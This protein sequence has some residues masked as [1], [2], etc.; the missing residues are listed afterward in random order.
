MNLH[1]TKSETEE[2]LTE[3][4]VLATNEIEHFQTGVKGTNGEQ[5]MI[6]WMVSVHR[7]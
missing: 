3:L 4:D 7:M 5:A 6:T 2:Q 1:E